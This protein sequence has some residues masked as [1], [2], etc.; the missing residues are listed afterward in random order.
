MI[1]INLK[2]KKEQELKE[3]NWGHQEKRKAKTGLQIYRLLHKHITFK[4]WT[5]LN[6]F[7]EKCGKMNPH[8]APA[9]AR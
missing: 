6:K 1:H 5:T 4:L 3:K 2:K 8:K 7:D 9:T